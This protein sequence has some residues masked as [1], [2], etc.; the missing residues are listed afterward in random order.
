MKK[1]W[2]T[3][4]LIVLV[5]VRTNEMVLGACKSRYGS[6]PDRSRPGCMSATAGVSC[7]NHDRS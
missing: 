2:K 5:R 7:Q 4:E 6:G 1:E 3:P